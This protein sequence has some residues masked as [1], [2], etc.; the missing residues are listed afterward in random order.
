MGLYN[1]HHQLNK[2][3]RTVFNNKKGP[4]KPSPFL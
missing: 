2:D 3:F 4:G 1:S